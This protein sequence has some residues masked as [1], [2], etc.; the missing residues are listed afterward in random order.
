MKL[1]QMKRKREKMIESVPGLVEGK[2]YL[3]FTDNDFDGYIPLNYRAFKQIGSE[4]FLGQSAIPRSAGIQN[5]RDFEEL[6]FTN[7]SIDEYYNGYYTPQRKKLVVF[8]INEKYD[9]IYGKIQVFIPASFDLDDVEAFSDDGFIRYNEKSF[10]LVKKVLR[11][12]KNLIQA[13]SLLAD[14]RAKNILNAIKNKKPYKVKNKEEL[15]I[16]IFHINPRDNLNNLDVSNV[17]D[18]SAMF[19]GSTFN[20]NISKWDVSGVTNMT[21]MF[22]DS[23]FDGD[24]SSWDVSS[25]TEARGMFYSANF[26]GDISDWNFK[27]LTNYYQFC[28][29]EQVRNGMKVPTVMLRNI[30]KQTFGKTLPVEHRVFG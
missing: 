15:K 8:I 13:F 23:Y 6:T 12:K 17:V 14:P 30:I 21:N 10:K 25:V 11:F 26:N 9:D 1:I 18:M 22:F 20:G 2:D 19:Y 5:K 7:L 16:A 4:S 24:I 28:T 3:V 29:R 27:N